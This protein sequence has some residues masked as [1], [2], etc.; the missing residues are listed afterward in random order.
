MIKGAMSD[1]AAG[2]P[3]PELALLVGDF[4]HRRDV[5]ADAD[6]GLHT[7]DRPLPY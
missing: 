6:Q 7:R 3:A 4:T 2:L 1:R 5:H